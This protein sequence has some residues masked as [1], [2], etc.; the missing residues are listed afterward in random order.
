M[1]PNIIQNPAT[2]TTA[3]Q[4]SKISSSFQQLLKALGGATVSLG[5]YFSLFLTSA[6]AAS[7]VTTFET[8]VGDVT[9][10]WSGEDASL[11]GIIDGTE[12]SGHARVGFNGHFYDL[13]NSQLNPST[14]SY[15]LGSSVLEEYSINLG[16][17]SGYHLYRHW[18]ALVLDNDP[19]VTTVLTAEV[20]SQETTETAVMHSGDGGGVVGVA[21]TPEPTLTLGL[22]ALGGLMLGSKRKSKG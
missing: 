16:N 2:A 15:D 22:I 11:D 17:T 4:K 8:S 13:F 9:L 21:T 18:G 14:F 7:F 1:H 6:Q 5:A 19:I 12:L 3:S 10:E 20:L